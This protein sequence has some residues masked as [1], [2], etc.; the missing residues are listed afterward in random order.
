[1]RYSHLRVECH[2]NCPYQYKLRYVEHIKTVQ[3]PEADN[4]LICGNTIHKGAETDL[5]QAIEFYY[6]NYP[7]IN[8]NHINEVIKFEYLIPKIHEILAN[9]N[10]Y[11]KELERPR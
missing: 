8:D 5:K 7:I 6:S 1:M 4:A 9:V 2:N 11:K 3:A 10:V